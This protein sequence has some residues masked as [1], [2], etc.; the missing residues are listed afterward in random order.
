MVW[1]HT[2]RYVLLGEIMTGVVTVADRT[3]EP[4]RVSDRLVAVGRFGRKLHRDWKYGA[5]RWVKLRQLK[6]FGDQLVAVD[7]NQT[8]RVERYRPSPRGASYMVLTDIHFLPRQTAEILD[9]SAADL[10]VR[11]RIDAHPHI[12]S[13]GA[14]P[15]IASRL[16]GAFHPSFH[17]RH[18]SA[19]IS[20]QR[21]ERTPPPL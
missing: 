4:A 10:V 17:R 15:G 20:R 2:G 13:H 6:L 19:R 12:D 11:P 9:D 1:L 18:P 5:G 21:A 16:A 3:R 8:A 7:E 14:V